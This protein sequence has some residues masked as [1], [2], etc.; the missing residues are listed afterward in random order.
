MLITPVSIRLLPTIKEV[1]T[2]PQLKDSSMTVPP[3]NLIRRKL[4]AEPIQ[5]I[6]K[7]TIVSILHR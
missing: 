5:N 3:T 1:S 6:I 7:R 2:K 4:L